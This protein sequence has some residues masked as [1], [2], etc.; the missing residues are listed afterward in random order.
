[1]LDT[2]DRNHEIYAKFYVSPKNET[3]NNHRG[4]CGTFR[5]T[6]Q[7]DFLSLGDLSNIKD[8]EESEEY[9]LHVLAVG[10]RP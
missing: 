9:C 4:D 5:D 1:M 3:S 6:I 2:L 10:Q 8:T 7:Y